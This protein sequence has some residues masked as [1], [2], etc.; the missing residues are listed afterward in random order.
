MSGIS[1]VFDI[2]NNTAWSGFGGTPCIIE[3]IASKWPAL[4]RWTPDELKSRCG[5]EI[6]NAFMTDESFAGTVLQQVNRTVQSSFAEIITK[7]FGG[8]G[9]EA[10]VSYYLRVEPDTSVYNEMAKDFDIPEIG[11]PFNPTWTG[12]WMGERGNATPFHHDWWHGLLAQISG[13]KRFTLVHPFDAPR[14]QSGWPAE[15]RYDLRNIEVLPAGAPELMDL[16]QCYEGVLK[17]GDL[18][19]VP[20]YWWHQVVTL[21]D[22]NISIPIRFDTTQ[23]PD[24]SLFQLSQHSGLRT[25]TNQPM[26]EIAEIVKHL[27]NNRQQFLDREREM[28][29]ALTE[30]RGLN[31]TAEEIIVMI[32]TA[33][34][35]IGIGDRATHR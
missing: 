18:L 12:I 14:L 28:I 2:E 23:S 20:P 33:K 21:D 16:E 1:P 19:Y 7:I 34:E 30:V 24:V 10:G 9:S 29:V 13:T 4:S 17:P 11:R 5:N 26:T 8:A 25:L 22:G 27:R 31:A 35:G 32:E 3:G 15:S 6:V